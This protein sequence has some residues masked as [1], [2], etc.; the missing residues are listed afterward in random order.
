MDSL[1]RSDCVN[2]GISFL[3]IFKLQGLKPQV[4]KSQL[5]LMINFH[6]RTI[7]FSVIG[8]LSAFHY[9]LLLGSSQPRWIQGI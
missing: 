7:S 6:G 5:E 4:I 3:D 9:P 2:T 1:T 8:V